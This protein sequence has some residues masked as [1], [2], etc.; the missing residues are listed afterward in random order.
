LVGRKWSK[1]KQKKWRL[2]K[3]KKVE[4]PDRQKTGGANTKKSL[5]LTRGDGGLRDPW[6]GVEIKATVWGLKE[7]EQIQN[8]LDIKSTDW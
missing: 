6:Y 2:S 7:S 1:I 3:R 8:E 5:Q 4:E